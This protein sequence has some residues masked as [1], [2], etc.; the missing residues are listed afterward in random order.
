MPNKILINVGVLTN[1]G[2]VSA[3]YKALDLESKKL[4]DYFQIFNSTKE[5][6]NISKFLRL[7]K[8]YVQYF[9]LIKKYEYL[10]INPS[11]LP[12]SFYRDSF[13]TYLGL[14]RNKK[15]IVFW[16]GWNE[17][18]YNKLISSKLRQII[19]KKTFSKADAFVILGKIFEQKLFDLG[20]NPDK[21][22]L[23]F[24]NSADNSHL[25]G[26]KLSRDISEKKEITLLFIA[27]FDKNK[28]MFKSVEIFK[29]VQKNFPEI[30]FKLILAGDGP[31]YKKLNAHINQQKIKNIE[32]TG[33]IGG[34]E[35]HKIFLRS[36]ILLF[37][38]HY[39]EGMPL[40]ILEAMTYGLPIISSD[41]GGIPDLIIDG[42][43]GFMIPKN[44]NN[45][46]N[47]YV[48]AI[49]IF[50]KHPDLYKT[51]SLKNRN[52]AENNLTP[53]NAG[54]KLINFINS[55]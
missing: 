1:P 16:H 40:S 42:E 4:A 12:N 36:D 39:G 28:G 14:I 19:F 18:F 7:I 20:V 44:S 48:K 2:G 13:F 52:F 32:L 9:H 6:N 45:E 37:P 34:A 24:F 33:F 54:R 49:E 50:I 21:K 29:L 53:E 25:I 46:L 5:K 8:K 10:L 27:R 26:K 55:I 23:V 51:I 3:L 11:L 15:I 30:K 22:M 17:E 43:N 35:K 47:E 41:V 38:S 31:E